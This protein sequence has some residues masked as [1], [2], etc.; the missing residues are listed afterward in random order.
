MPAVG[1]WDEC[2]GDSR[3]PISAKLRKKLN[4]IL[5]MAQEW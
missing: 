4:I 5:I 2:S 3:S 1:K